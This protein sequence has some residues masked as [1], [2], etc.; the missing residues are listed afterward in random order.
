MCLFAVFSPQFKLFRIIFKCIFLLIFIPH[1]FLHSTTECKCH[2]YI[3]GDKQKTTYIYKTG[4]C[5]SI[6]D[7]CTQWQNPL[8]L[9]WKMIQADKLHS[10]FWICVGWYFQ[11]KSSTF[12]NRLSLV[13]EKICD[14]FALLW[15]SRSMLEFSRIF[16]SYK[17]LFQ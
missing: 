5:A 12:E 14:S 2:F 11:N 6:S 10:S 16:D 17:I 8:S 7:Y 1:F 4:T 3:C 15:T 13:Q 9:L